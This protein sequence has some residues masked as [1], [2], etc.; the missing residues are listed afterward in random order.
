MDEQEYEWQYNKESHKQYGLKEEIFKNLTDFYST[1]TDKANKGVE[2]VVRK[3]FSDEKRKDMYEGLM[4]LDNIIPT[5]KK[6][7]ER[8]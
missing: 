7:I 5:L 6:K 2:Y 8:H 4:M 1:I 3:M